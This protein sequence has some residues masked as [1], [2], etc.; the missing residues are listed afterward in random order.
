M[1]Q[2]SLYHRI[3]VVILIC[4]LVLFFYLCYNLEQQYQR[5]EHQNLIKVQKLNLT[6][7]RHRHALTANDTS[8]IESWM[9]FNYISAVFAVPAD[10][11]KNS[12]GLNDSKYPYLT[13]NH[14]A[15][16]HKLNVQ[17]FTNNLIGTVKQYLLSNN[18][19]GSNSLPIN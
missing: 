3:L 10:Y 18:P 6:N 17:T 9:T 4:L 16:A 19:A 1:S 7:I 14:Y 13:I 15:R 12:L 8:L 5:I 11:L 2:R